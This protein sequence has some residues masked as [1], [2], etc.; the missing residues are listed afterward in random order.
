MKKTKFFSFSLPSFKIKFKRGDSSAPTTIAAPDSEFVDKAPKPLLLLGLLSE[1]AQYR[2][3]IGV[4]M[5]LLLLAVGFS[6]A[7]FVLSD[8]VESVRVTLLDVTQSVQQLRGQVQAAASGNTDVAPDIE[9][10]YAFIAQKV[11]DLAH[12]TQ[13]NL[14]NMRMLTLPAHQVEPQWSDQ[15]WDYVVGPTML[16]GAKLDGF[17]KV[18][19]GFNQVVAVQPQFGGLASGVND[20]LESADRALVLAT[21]AIDRR[22]TVPDGLLSAVREMQRASTIFSNSGGNAVD[23]AAMDS[24]RA[25]V[26]ELMNSIPV[27]RRGPVTTELYT[28][29]NDDLSVSMGIVSASFNRLVQDLALDFSRISAETD[30][31]LD[32]ASR[33]V[34]T[35]DG[36]LTLWTIAG[37]L[38]ILGLS[39]VAILISI[40][41]KASQ[42]SAYYA[43]KER[44]ETDERVR[45]IMRELRPISNGDLTQALTVTEHVTGSI[46]D[47]MNATVESLRDVLVAVGDSTRKV[48]SAIEDMYMQTEEA[49]DITQRAAS[50]ASASR[51]ASEKG[52]STVEDAV[53][54]ANQQRAMIQDVSKAVKRLGEVF[55]SVMRVT[56]VIDDLTSTSEVLAIN[57]A[58]KAEDAGEHGGPFRVIA[59]EQRRLT[60]DTKR[61]LEEITLLMQTMLSETQGV[62]QTVER[63]TS[64]MVGSTQLWQEVQS[65]LTEIRSASQAMESLMKLVDKT[66]KVQ[67]DAASRAVAVMGDLS[68]STMKFKTSNDE[69]LIA[70]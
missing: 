68:S 34:P 63:V 11:A 27:T 1:K 24:A 48:E 57:T 22:E 19:D 45:Q 65:S 6:F 3:T 44:E 4:S 70:A 28:L 52:A 54:K 59:D 5:L 26:V 13:A 31:V 39:G 40:N 51:E 61:S 2:L 56:D 69:G 66:A 30:R 35:P 64:E 23:L 49:S 46:A 37:S 36:V 33:S 21:S 12:T 38:F 8:R 62:I 43:R 20:L 41:A 32:G 29:L 55:Q 47:R 60:D 17:M 25:K 67:G 53:A 18:L 9:A 16:L 14:S 58:L 42:F 15:L 7:A 50:Q 10:N